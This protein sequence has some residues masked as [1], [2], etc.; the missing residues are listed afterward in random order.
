MRLLATLD[1][2]PFD[3]STSKSIFCCSAFQSE[4]TRRSA[5]PS[6]F[7]AARRNLFLTQR[8]SPKAV[9]Q[10]SDGSYCRRQDRDRG[11]RKERG[12]PSIFTAA[13]SPFFRRGPFQVPLSKHSRPQIPSFSAATSPSPPPPPPPLRKGLATTR[14]TRPH[15]KVTP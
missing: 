7:S 13:G 3:G 4:H 9:L 10:R 11:C 12:T 5:E 8:S 14:A 15:S 1:V 2:L 6:L